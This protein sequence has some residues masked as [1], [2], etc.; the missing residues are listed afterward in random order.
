[1]SL[2]VVKELQIDPVLKAFLFLDN[3]IM[4]G[5]AQVLS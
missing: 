4:K 1:M 5:I 3:W 2:K